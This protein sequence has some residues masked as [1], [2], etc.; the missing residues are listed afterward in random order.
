MLVRPALFVAATLALGGCAVL[1]PASPPA[2]FDLSAPTH[3]AEQRGTLRGVMVVA[4]PTA[5]QA[6]DSQRIVARTAGGEI[7][8]VPNAQWSDRLTS[9]VQAR[10]IDAFENAGHLRTVGRSSDRLSADYDLISDIRNF[11]I[12][13]AGGTPT[14]YVD[15]AVRIVSDSGGRVV[16]GKVF[17]ARVPV[18]G[19]TGPAATA[20]LQQALQIVL[21]DVVRW[22]TARI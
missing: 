10:I 20:G 8:Y 4:M 16:A 14:A 11:G 2:T 12:D 21:G 17:S 3:V 1:F 18:S 13:A 6:L 5:I 9:L 19:V 7:T 22:A 15:I